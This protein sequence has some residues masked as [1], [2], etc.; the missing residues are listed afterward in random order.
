MYIRRDTRIIHTGKS[1]YK[2]HPSKMKSRLSFNAT[3]RT[4]EI[5]YD[6]PAIRYGS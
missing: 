4:N 2:C 5:N 6:H 1:G 3:D